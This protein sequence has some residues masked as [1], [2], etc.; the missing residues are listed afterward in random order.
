MEADPRVYRTLLSAAELQQ[1]KAEA[2]MSVSVCLPALNEERTIG[3]I[4][5]AI[6]SLMPALVDELIVVDSGSVD[7]TMALAAQAGAVV[8]PVASILPHIEVERGGKG[9]VLW[10]SLAVARGDIVVWLD[11]DTRNF[12]TSFVLDLIEPLLVDPELRMTKAFYD[13][14]L[15]NSEGALTTGGAR[16]TELLVRPLAHI[17]FPE[18]LGFIQP[19]SGEYAAHRDVLRSLPLFTGYGVEIGLLIDVAQEVGLDRVVQVD[20]GSRIHRNQEILALG[21]MA[22]QVARTMTT[23]AEELGRLKLANDWPELMRQFRSDGEGP[24][25]EKHPLQVVE[26][27]PMESVSG[28]EPTTIH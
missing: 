7:D 1:L 19:L 4:C 5:R 23:R 24:I 12:D 2:G 22:F 13:R 3:E 8:Y 14:P 6:R 27:P 18:L 10:R 11:S 9:E 16:V 17:L 20:L 28:S 26:L 21:R 25:A 15:Q